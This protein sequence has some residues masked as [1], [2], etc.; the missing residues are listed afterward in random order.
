[1]AQVHNV[2]VGY[3]NMQVIKGKDG[4]VV[5]DAGT[6]GSSVKILAELSKL[7]I[8]PQDVRLIIC[9]HGHVDHVGGAGELRMATGAQIVLHKADA[10]FVREGKSAPLSP[11]GFFSSLFAA[12]I[13]RIKILPLEP[14]IIIEGEMDISSYGVE[15]ILVPTPGH[16]PGSISVV[17]AEGVAIVGDLLAGGMLPWRRGPGLHF[18]LDNPAEA[19]RSVHAILAKA[20]GLIYAGHGGPFEPDQVRKA[21]ELQ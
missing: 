12:I 4:A 11:T 9:T 1:M 5:V 3:Y 20:T 14:D 7:G 16:T 6:P 15:G 18:L 19:L 8:F 13:R 2:S 17:L 21:L 10:K